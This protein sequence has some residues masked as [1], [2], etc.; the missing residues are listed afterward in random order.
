MTDNDLDIVSVL[1]V[2]DLASLLSAVPTRHDDTPLTDDE[3]HLAYQ[4]R[5]VHLAAARDLLALDLEVER[6]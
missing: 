5:W 3:L 6:S 1:A 2:T 4:A